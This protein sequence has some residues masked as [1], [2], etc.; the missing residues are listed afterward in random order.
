MRTARFTGGG[1]MDGAELEVPRGVGA[2]VTIERDGGKSHYALDDQG[3]FRFAG[4]N[5][6]G[7]AMSK[8]MRAFS[9]QARAEREQLEAAMRPVGCRGCGATFGSRGAYIT[10]FE[11]GEGSRCLP[12][13]A[14]GQLV[15]RDGVW[16]LPGS[17]VARR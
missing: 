9:E 11:Q 7:R 10:H 13:D 1:S 12:G 6:T 8:I 15:D 17:D 14:H 4:L 16:C 2:A 3:V 5:E